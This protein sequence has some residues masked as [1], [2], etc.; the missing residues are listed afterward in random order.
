MTNINDVIRTPLTDSHISRYGVPREDIIVY[1]DLGDEYDIEGLLT[2]E[3][4]YKIMLI[5]YKENTGHWV[6]IMKYELKGKKTLEYFNP[7][8]LYPSKKDFVDD[9]VLNDRLD[10]EQLFLN[11]LFHKEMGEADFDDLIYNKVK[12]QSRADNVNTCGRHCLMRLICMKEFNMDL[13]DYIKYMKRF[14]EELDASY[15]EIVASIIV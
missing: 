7:F 2:D 3:H 9:E 15:D 4:P 13:S 1:S 5:E 12:F 6:L 8:G 11:K 10:Q 14:R